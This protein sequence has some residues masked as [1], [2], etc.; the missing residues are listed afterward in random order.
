MD[1][2]D[3]AQQRGIVRDH[4]PAWRS[5][6][7]P[8]SNVRL[9]RLQYLARAAH[10]SHICDYEPIRRPL[11]R[12]PYVSATRERTDE[13]CAAIWY[14]NSWNTAYLPINDNHTFDNTGARFNVTKILTD[15]RLDDAKYQ[16]YSQPWVSAGFITSF[17]WYF[18][19]YGASEL[20]IRQS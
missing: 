7:E 6:L 1:D 10:Y 12:N 13:R 14:S 8:A 5:W 2:L 3:C 20:H 11:N 9:E 18:A 15:G 17:F 16:Q 19:L 4:V